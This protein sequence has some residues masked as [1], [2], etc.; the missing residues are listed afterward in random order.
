MITLGLI[1]LMFLVAAAITIK[2]WW[3]DG[4]TD[5]RRCP[6]CWYDMSGTDTL[7]CSECGHAAGRK[8]ELYQRQASKRVYRAGIAAMCLL[9]FASVYVVIPGP[10][11]NKVPRPLMR[12]AL[13]IAATPPAPPS[14]GPGSGLPVPVAALNTSKSAWDRLVWQHQA[15]IAF[16]AWADAVQETQGPITDAEL[17]RLVPLAEQAHLIFGQTGGLFAAEAWGYEAAIRRMVAQRTAAAG[18]ADRLLRAEWTLSELQ[19]VH[20]GCSGRPECARVPD[21]IIQQALAHPDA[22][23]RLFGLDRFG[24]VVHHVARNLASPMPPGREIVEAM[25]TGDPDPAVRA[26]AAHLVI[27][28]DGFLPKK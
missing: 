23:V 18:N 9:A 12:V 4:R 14:A 28:M 6:R 10:W 7:K 5:L 15:S 24:R 26:R 22:S 25:A 27:Y 20:S 8:S 21:A 17:A 19:Y 3:G 13:S 1:S 2:A 11:T 16:D